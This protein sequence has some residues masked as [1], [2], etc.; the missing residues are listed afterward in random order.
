[1]LQGL[2]WPFGCACPG[3]SRSMKRHDSCQFRRYRPVEAVTI[4]RVFCVGRQGPY[5]SR[6]EG[7]AE[8]DGGGVV[9]HARSAIFNTLVYRDPMATLARASHSR[10]RSCACRSACVHSINTRVLTGATS[11]RSIG[12]PSLANFQSHKVYDVPRGFQAQHTPF[13]RLGF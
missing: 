9:L 13:S 7:H 5:H 1:M 2:A 4:S 11:L 10:S 12:R 6:P 8:A 3:L